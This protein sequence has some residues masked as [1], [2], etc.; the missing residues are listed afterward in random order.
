MLGSKTL[1]FGAV[2]ARGAGRLNSPGNRVTP[3]PEGATVVI[4]HR[5]KDGKLTEYEG[6][7]EEMAPVCKG[8]PGHVDW[9]IIRPV[10]GLT[11]T[12]TIIVRFAAREALERWLQSPERHALLEKAKPL[13]AN[14]GEFFISSGMDFWF[15][16]EGAKAKVPVRWKQFLITWSAIYPL[17][18]VMPILVIPMMRLLGI[19]ANHLVD[20]LL[21]T[22][23]VVAS[24]V[25]VVMPRYTRLVQHW[26]FRG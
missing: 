10:P 7:M 11:N 6:W 16:P 13:L 21:V 15:M 12:Y 18:L 19:P 17:V 9:Q 26:L 8:A 4:T 22:G 3:V 25:Y 24:M 20:M 14:D 1:A 2:N 23:G 5:I